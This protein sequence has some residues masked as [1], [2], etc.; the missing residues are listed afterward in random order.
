[1]AVCIGSRLC[2][3]VPCQCF[4]G[5]LTPWQLYDR[6]FYGDLKGWSL[7]TGLKV[8]DRARFHTASVDS[9]SGGDRLGDVRALYVLGWA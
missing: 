6:V 4:G 8:C 9:G 2:E 3:N 1:M 7:T 5:R